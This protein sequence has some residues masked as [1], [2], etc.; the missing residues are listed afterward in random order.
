[1]LKFK[2]VKS[3]P[4]ILIFLMFMMI[5]GLSAVSAYEDTNQISDVGSSEENIN[6]NSYENNNLLSLDEGGQVGESIGSTHSGEGKNIADANTS[7]TQSADVESYDDI[8]SQDTTD[9]MGVTNPSGYNQFTSTLDENNIVKNGLEGN[10]S[11]LQTI[12]DAASPNDTITLT[13]DFRSLQEEINLYQSGIAIDKPLT[14]DG[15]GHY[16]SGNA[17]SAIFTLIRD[18]IYIKNIM[19]KEAKSGSGSG[20]LVLSSNVTVDSCNFTDN[21][22]G[23]FGGAVLWEGTNGR[24]INCIFTSN[25]AWDGGAVYWIGEGGTISQCTFKSNNVTSDGGAIYINSSAGELTIADS[26]FINNTAVDGGAIFNVHCFKAAILRSNFTNNTALEEGGAIS[27]HVGTGRVEDSNFIEN[28][29]QLAGAIFWDGEGGTVTGSNFKFNRATYGAAITMWAKNGSI[30]LSKF[31]NNTAGQYGGALY[32]SGEEDSVV[33]SLFEN[34]TAQIGGSLYWTGS[35]GTVSSCEFKNNNGSMDKEI[36][37]FGLSGTVDN[38]TMENN[39][40]SDGQN[41]IYWYGDYGKITGSSFINNT[42]GRKSSVIFWQGIHGEI[43]NSNFINN[44][45][46]AGAAV[47]FNKGYANIASS[48]FTFNHAEEGGAIYFGGGNNIV[49]NSIFTNNSGENGSAIYFKGENNTVTK[50]TFLDNKGKSRI[51]NVSFE[52]DGLSYIIVKYKGSNTYLNAIYSPVPVDFINVSFWAAGG[53]VNTEVVGTGQ[54]YAAMG[55][56][57]NMTFRG[58][59]EDIIF[60]RS[61]Y[62]GNDGIMN[63]T[64]DGIVGGYQLKVSHGE[65]SYYDEIDYTMDIDAPKISKLIYT[66]NIANYTYSSDINVTGS[67]I[68]PEYV[69]GSIELYLDGVKFKD[70]PLDMGVGNFTIGYILPAV[71]NLSFYYGGNDICSEYYSTNTS[72]EVKK[73]SS[74]ILLTMP[75][76]VIQNKVMKVKLRVIGFNVGDKVRLT[77]GKYV[78][79]MVLKKDGVVYFNVKGLKKGKYT[80]LGEY[81]GGT[82]YSYTKAKKALTVYDAKYTIKAPNVSTYYNSGKYLTVKVYKNGKLAPRLV[83]SIKFAGKTYKVKTNSKGIAKLA[84]SAVKPKKYKAIVQYSY[85]KATPIV[86]I[87]K[88][89]VKFTKI[90]KTV[91]RGKYFAMKVVNSGGKAV[92]SKKIVLKIAGKSI[93]RKTTKAGIVWAKILLKPRKYKI[94][95]KV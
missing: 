88:S 77:V 50:S 37:W 7:I 16:I 49:E 90:T 61:G 20:L 55:Q 26:D 72:F 43:R 21:L 39:Q 27:W 95:C 35:K 53:I 78:K 81:L 63:F 47:Y 42:G 62:T 29:G 48:N 84:V 68:L 9:S 57:I 11:E 33:N 71:H 89:S 86:K 5:I 8:S 17:I 54:D 52:Y 92:K 41:L 82:F 46:L 67:I 24:I 10:F 34:N 70:I 91:K 4:L 18:N 79:E 74:K 14:I 32:C 76:I 15:D 80:I 59:S 38:I 51:F 12:I 30:I 87:V 19:F 44:S 23:N 85:Q 56:L 66:M 45:A 31:I 75:K 73:L 36:Y 93:T 28:N 58:A 83:V 60:F 64:L 25:T 2:S 69:N 13:K 3:K 94:V 65:D 22:A 6:L 40:L 1:M